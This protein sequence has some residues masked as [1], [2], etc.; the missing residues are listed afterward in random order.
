MQRLVQR[1]H[2]ND[3]AAFEY[4][5]HL[6]HQKIYCFIL[7][8]IQDSSHAQ[9]L[10]QRFFIR[11]WEKRQ[12]LSPDKPLE[13]Q[14]FVIARNLVIDELRKMA[15]EKSFIE[16]FWSRRKPT[17]TLTEETVLFNDLQEHFEAVVESLPQRR[18]E[19]FK[20]SRHQGL[21]YQEIAHELS[22][23][24]KTV[25]IQMSKAL[26]VV[27]AKLSAFLHLLL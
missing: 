3:E 10:T 14:A 11:L 16:Y 18:R 27:R 19:I 20:L 13:A 12:L 15:R 8:Y 4:I 23:S 26:K 1:L 7:R 22:I 21:T 9:E 2:E 5:Y 24:P 17:S 6:I 25:E